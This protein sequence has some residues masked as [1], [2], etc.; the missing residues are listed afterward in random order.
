MKKLD[1]VNNYQNF[2]VF[3]I[4]Q[5]IIFTKM[6]ASNIDNFEEQFKSLYDLIKL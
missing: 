4:I 5:N 3:L 6:K 2:N 1:E